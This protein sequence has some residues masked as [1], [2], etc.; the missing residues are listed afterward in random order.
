M[1]KIRFGLIGHGDVVKRKSLRALQEHPYADVV[2]VLGRNLANVKQFAE[3][4]GIE[5]YTIDEKT[6]F[7]QNQLD[8]VYIA[9]PPNSHKH[10]I[11][12]ALRN[13]LCVYVEKPFTLTVNE[14]KTICKLV[15]KGNHKLTVAHYR[16]ELACFKKVKQLLDEGMIGDVR[17]ASIQILQSKQNTLIAKT[18]ENWRTQPHISGGGYFHDLAPH[19]IDLMHQYFGE[20]KEVCGSSAN[21]SNQYHADDLVQGIIR[22]KNDVFVQGCW[23]FHVAQTAEKDECIIY[24]SNGHIRFSFFGKEILLE[25]EDGKQSFSFEL[26][27][28]IQQPMM[29]ETIDYFLG[30]RD[31]PCP[32]EAGL[33]TMEVMEAFTYNG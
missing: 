20:I 12:T 25:N 24:G 10:Y 3:A 4:Y 18:T 13:K 22:F 21:Q 5:S 16:R 14:A 6:F 32:A 1:K 7:E 33:L 23:A 30:K 2:A 26:P 17:F 15:T 19:Q 29:N 8:A 11:Q 28:T 9:T 31:N 27:K